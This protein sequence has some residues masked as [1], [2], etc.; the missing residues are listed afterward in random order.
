MINSTLKPALALL[1]ISNPLFSAFAAEISFTDMSEQQVHL[2]APA[3]RIV[4]IPIPAASMLVGLDES[5]SKLV[6]MHPFAGVAAS[7]GMLGT[8]FPEILHVRSDM[9]GNNFTPNIEALL[10]VEPD[11]VWQWGH[12]GDDIITP[13]R[14]A[15]LTVATLDYGKEAYT[16]QWIT[17]M[18]KTLG[19][20]TK[21]AK[22]NRWRNQVIEQLENS[23]AIIPE[24]LQP[25]V[26]YLSHFKQSIQTFGSTSHNN[27]DFALAGGLSLNR[28]LTGPRTLNIE[29][30][31]VWDPDVILLGNFETD[32]APSDIYDS[33]M[34]SDVAAVKNRR[35]FKLPIGGFIWDAPN[36]ETPLYWQWLSM[37]FHPETVSWPL[38]NEIRL[39]YQQLYGYQISDAEI[40][41]VLQLELNQKSKDYLKI[42]GKPDA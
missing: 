18:G 23:S 5:S 19:R 1:L 14:N 2:S 24:S 4:V 22:M 34:L 10:A 30:I 37:I 28:D 31:L 29:Q 21:A 38:R 33:P 27:Y 42:M 17:L 12:R 16:Q 9:V 26:L 20:D 11:L 36:Q 8:M 25:K 3:E 32:L 7:E 35:V 13:M 41:R 40:D 39:R 15:G 6:G